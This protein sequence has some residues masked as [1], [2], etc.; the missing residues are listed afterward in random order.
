MILLLAHPCPRTPATRSQCSPAHLRPG[1]TSDIS[2]Q[3][4]TAVTGPQG[5][6]GEGRADL[7]SVSRHWRTLAPMLQRLTPD[8]LLRIGGLAQHQK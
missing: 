6:E 1:A 2:G 4:L 5:R 3:E 8:D 7:P